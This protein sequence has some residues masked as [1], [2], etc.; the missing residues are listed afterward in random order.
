MYSYYKRA[1]QKGILIK[2]YSIVVKISNAPLLLFYYSETL[3]LVFFKFLPLPTGVKMPTVHVKWTVIEWVIARPRP[4]CS[5]AC[6]CNT[7]SIGFL[8]CFSKQQDSLDSLP[9]VAY[10][11]YKTNWVK[12]YISANNRHQLMWSKQS[13]VHALCVSFQNI[14]FFYF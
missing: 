10:K 14:C 12:S 6:T 2:E 4:F 8:E 3:T 7:W 5:K 11:K 1:L 9:L 13:A